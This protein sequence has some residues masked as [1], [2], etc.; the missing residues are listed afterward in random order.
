[1]RSDVQPILSQVYPGNLPIERESRRVAISGS[2]LSTLRRTSR[3]PDAEHRALY[4]LV[5]GDR[6]PAQPGMSIITRPVAVA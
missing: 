2:S 4:D 5:A 1:M 6:T 3:T